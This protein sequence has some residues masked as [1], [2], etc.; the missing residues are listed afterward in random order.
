MEEINVI[1]KQLSNFLSYLKRLD[2]R[3]FIFAKKNSEVLIILFC[4]VVSCNFGP[5]PR[6]EKR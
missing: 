4:F 2:Y 6:T 3:K 5:F 1:V